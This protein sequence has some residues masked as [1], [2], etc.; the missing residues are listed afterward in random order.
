MKKKIFIAI[1]I[2]FI[3]LVAA[4]VI[5]PFIYKDRIIEMVKKEANKSLNANINFDNNIRLSL[6]R[7]FPDMTITINNFVIANKAPFEGDTLVNIRSLKASLDIKSIFKGEKIKVHK[8]EAYQPDI[9]LHVLND[10][11]YSAN[12]DITLPDT[13]TEPEDTSTSFIVALKKYSLHEGHIL[14]NDESMAMRFELDNIEHSGYGDFT[15]DLFNLDTKTTADAFTFNYDGVNYLSKAKTKLD[16]IVEIDLKNS[17]YTFKE[18]ELWLN[19]LFL[20]F[21]GYI[22]M[23]EEDI[24]MDIKFKAPK[25]DF[26]N[27]LSMIPAIYAKDFEKLTASG[28]MDFNGQLKGIY[29]DS[30]FPGYMINL[31]VQNGT[32]KYPDLPLPLNNVQLSMNVNCPDGITDHVVVDLKKLHLELDKEPFDASLLVKT[33]ISDPYLQ[34]VVKGKIDL[35]N[36]RN[37]IPL[38][39]QTELSGVIK[40]NI[41]LSGKMSSLEKEEY[42]KFKAT[43][44][45]IF[46]N[47]NYYTQDLPAKVVIPIMNLAFSPAIVNLSN[48]QL[49]MGKSDLAANGSLSNFIAY[50]F[51]KGELNGNLNLGSSFLDINQFMSSSEPGSAATSTASDTS[52]SLSAIELPGNILFAMKGDFNRVIYDNMDLSNV[53]CDLLLKDKILSIVNLSSGMFN[54]K[55]T[56]NGY[57]DTRTPDK[58]RFDFNLNIEDFNILQT[59]KTFITV[60]KFAPIAKYMQGDFDAVLN[61]NS[62]LGKDMMP[63]LMSLISQG[64]LNIEQVTLMDFKPTNAIANTL[65]IDQFKSLSIKNI[66]PSYEIKNGRIFLK[67]SIRFD[68]EKTKLSVIGSTGLDQSLDYDWRITM[69]ASQLKTQSTALMSQLGLNM[70]SPMGEYVTIFVKMTGKVDN[71]QIKTSL[72]EM[73]KSVVTG[74]KD[75]AKAQVD[76]AKLEAEARV[77]AAADSARKQAAL[78]L[79]QQ[80]KL[81]EAKKKEEE[82]KLLDQKEAAKKKLEEEA[83]KKLKTII[84]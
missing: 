36:I 52:S 14:Y 70:N 44:D 71:P 65:K 17:K 54:G 53:K 11:L 5:I 25:T 49:K 78:L 56:A 80:K 8:V 42:E 76:K 32:F 28:S 57:F 10:S 29:N 83:K 26:K 30:L 12:W 58:P 72:K 67:D 34:A 18:N 81:L 79:E 21:E 60:Q 82:K 50:L 37:L 7:H 68:V 73:G 15:L 4:I 51:G 46:T 61:V 41:E 38:D 40:S 84:K 20:Q 19:N 77:R 1:G 13:S 45:L 24:A 27:L 55:M 59:F 3:L 43:G 66:K 47:L 62:E 39:E 75:A 2:F 23:P 74:V 48:F 9:Y 33:P 22:L 35:G 69:P 6:F 31:A 64:K 63:V 16:A